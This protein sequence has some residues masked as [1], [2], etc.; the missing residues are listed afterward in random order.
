MNRRFP[1]QSVCD[2]VMFCIEDSLIPFQHREALYVNIGCFPKRISLISPISI[3][4]PLNHTK[5]PPKLAI[6]AKTAASSVSKEA[7][8]LAKTELKTLDK[9]LG[10]I[11]L[12]KRFS[13]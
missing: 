1:M 4:K 5:P 12:K 6:V 10:A 3:S 8:T 11:Q 2:S 7:T 13:L 9:I